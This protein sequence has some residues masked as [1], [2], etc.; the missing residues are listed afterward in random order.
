MRK[1]LY[2]SRCQTPDYIWQYIH[3]VGTVFVLIIK[4]CIIAILYPLTQQSLSLHFLYFSR[5]PLSHENPIIFLQHFHAIKCFTKK[6]VLF[7]S[8]I[9]SKSCNVKVF[10][11]TFVTKMDLMTS[12]IFWYLQYMY[13]ESEDILYHHHCWM[14]IIIIIITIRCLLSSVFDVYHYYC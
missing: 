3:S 8:V 14:F 10:F 7:S 13:I 6:V 9:C 1:C 12:Y 5:K 11:M 2:W 4:L